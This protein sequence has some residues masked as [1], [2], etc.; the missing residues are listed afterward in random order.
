METLTN[1]LAIVEAAQYR[2]L[3]IVEAARI[4]EAAQYTSAG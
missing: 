2:K 1:G 3:G 4:V